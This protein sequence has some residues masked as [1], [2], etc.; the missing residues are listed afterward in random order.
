MLLMIDN[1]D[2]FT[3]NL[4]RY[5]EELGERV[6]VFRNDDISLDTIRALKPGGIV[7]SPGPKTPERAG[8]TLDIIKAF[9][10]E[11]PILGICLGH[12]AIGFAFGASVVR[13]GRPMHGKLSLV[14]HDGAGVFKGI[15]NPLKVTRYHSLVVDGASLPGE[16]ELT[17]QTCDGAV[18]GLRHR[19]YPVE[20]VQFHPE[21]ELTE[22]GHLLLKN[23]ADRCRN[24]A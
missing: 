11:I 9:K 22:C 10:A 7:I 6:L 2:S 1:Y 23:F 15:K 4:V 18:M 14:Y 20:G 17:C 16:L 13:A 5:L 21:A 12:Q 19:L 8:L 24:G 3:Y